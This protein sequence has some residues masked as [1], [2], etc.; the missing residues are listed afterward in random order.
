MT[1]N[2]E[3]ETIPVD[4]IDEN[5]WNPN[6][7]PERHFEQLKAEYER[8]GYAQLILVRPTG[9][10]RYELVDG[11]HRWKAARQVGMEEMKAVVMDLDDEEARLTTLNMNDIKGT[12]NPVKLAETLTEIDRS[13]TELAEVTVMEPEEIEAHQMLADLNQVEREDPSNPSSDSDGTGEDTR[14]IELEYSED[15]YQEVE[16]YLIEKYQGESVEDAAQ[17]HLLEAAR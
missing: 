10:D 5:P 8:V 4:K 6:E 15:E 12:D 13:P 2:P 7:M 3:V 1:E 14:V 16:S 9:E 17:M 11:E